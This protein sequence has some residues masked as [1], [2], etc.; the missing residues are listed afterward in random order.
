MY[1]PL[2]TTLTLLYIQKTSLKK[3]MKTHTSSKFIKKY[4]PLYFF[5]NLFSH[6]QPFQFDP[7]NPQPGDIPTTKARSPLEL[8]G[9]LRIPTSQA[10]KATYQAWDDA[11]MDGNQKSQGNSRNHRAWDGGCKPVVNCK[12]HGISTRYISPNNWWVEFA[13]FLVARKSSMR[14]WTPLKSNELNTPTW[15]YS[16]GFLGFFEAGEIPILP[17]PIIFWEYPAVRFSWMEMV[18][19]FPGSKLGGFQMIS[20]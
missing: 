19:H 2:K 10:W 8:W 16:H 11:G 9:S 12:L 13:G 3:Y 6:H 4:H 14:N 17:W 20:M 5:H 1:T 18:D 15:V 7:T